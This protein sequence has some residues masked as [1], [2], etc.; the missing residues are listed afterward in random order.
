MSNF[1]N[2]E[3]ELRAYD[4]DT[5]ALRE[6]LQS[7][8]ATALGT[9]EMQRAV[10]DVQPVNPNK[11]IRLRN[12]G[13]QTTLAIKERISDT[14]DGTGEVEMVVEDFDKALLFLASLGN[15]TPRSIQETRRELYDFNGTEVS[16]DSWPRIKDLVEIE[17]ASEEEVRAV[18]AQLGISADQLTALSVEQYYLDTLGTDVKTTS[19]RFENE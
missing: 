11:W 18:A 7:L 10:F 6:T 5:E 12:E 4:V 16:I 8:G 3:I 1:E 9:K 15:Y 13:D 14:V 17:G 2:R 19:L